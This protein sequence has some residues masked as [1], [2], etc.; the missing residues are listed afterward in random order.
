MLKN[1]LNH[2]RHDFRME[3]HEFAEFLGATRTMYNAWENN[4]KQP[5]NEWIIK[6]SLKTNRDAREFMYITE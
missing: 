3:Q 4:K 2:L 5:N 1:K 6:I